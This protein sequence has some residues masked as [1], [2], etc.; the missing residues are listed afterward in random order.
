MPF[1]ME[2]DTV[3]GLQKKIKKTKTGGRKQE[4]KYKND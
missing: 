3:E 1:V 2:K 4:R